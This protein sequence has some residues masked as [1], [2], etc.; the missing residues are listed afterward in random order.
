[1]SNEELVAEM[2]AAAA[3]LTTAA[4]AA[5]N[6]DFAAAEIGVED[7]LFRAQSLIARIQQAA[8]AQSGSHSSGYGIGEPKADPRDRG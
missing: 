6:G 3:S 1:M 2:R 7:A 5:Q 4:A 8:Q